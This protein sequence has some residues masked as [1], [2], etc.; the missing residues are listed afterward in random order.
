MYNMP[1]RMLHECLKEV[2][3]FIY[4]KTIVF[5]FP[6]RWYDKNN[7]AL[8]FLQKKRRLRRKQRTNKEEEEIIE[9]K[10]LR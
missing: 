5:P 3:Y 6:D 9:K 1:L 7:W 8:K 2:F 10:L 4:V